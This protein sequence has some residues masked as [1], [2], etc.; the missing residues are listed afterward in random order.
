V[1]VEQYQQFVKSTQAKL[2]EP[3]L[4]KE[5]QTPLEESVSHLKSE[6]KRFEST[7]K[8]V[9]KQLEQDKA[10]WFPTCTCH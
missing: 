6:L 7:H 2:A 3:G 10:L 1:P 4:K 5:Q 9:T 8:L